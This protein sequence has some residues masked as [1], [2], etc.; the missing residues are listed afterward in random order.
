M[1]VKKLDL[2]LIRQIK[3][4]KGQFISITLMVVLA[5]MTY[6]SLNMVGDNLKVSLDTYY[7]MTNFGDIFTEVVKIPNN[8]VKNLE[9]IPGVVKAQ[10]RVTA[11]VLFRTEDPEEKVRVRM[12]SIPDEEYII[13]DNFVIEGEGIPKE[14]NHVVVL[15]QFAKARGIKLGDKIT[16]YISGRE[17]S[18][19]VT[20]I[21]GNPEFI[22]LMESEVNILPD[23]AKFGI[24]YVSEEM[25]QST[26]GFQGS[27]NEI[28]LKTDKAY[29][30]RID[31][32]IE[33]IEDVLDPYGLKKVVKKENQLSNN[34][35]EQ[36]IGQLESMSASITILFLGAAGVI[37]YIML[38]RI[39]NNDRISIGVLKALGYTNRE[40]LLHYL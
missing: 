31:E 16:P 8:A 20:G 17:H 10:G 2:R 18:L 40:V 7:E 35:M 14:V 12:I 34:I 13:N 25:A 9:S 28:V 27:Y 37:I 32:I 39:V 6:I 24:L 36:E 33:E 38:G 3:D 26:L 30:D 15:E 19:I 5:L 23:P 11:D 4:T 21:I 1:V 29:D 22:Y